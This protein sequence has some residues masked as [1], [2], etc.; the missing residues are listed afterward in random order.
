MQEWTTCK[1]GL[2]VK[3][4]CFSETIAYC[5]KITNCISY[6]SCGSCS[7]LLVSL[8]VFPQHNLLIVQTTGYTTSFY[9][10]FLLFFCLFNLEFQNLLLSAPSVLSCVL[11]CAILSILLFSTLLS[12]PCS[13][14]SL[15]LFTLFSDLPYCSLF[16]ICYPFF[17]LFQLLC[18][19]CFSLILYYYSICSLSISLHR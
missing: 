15:C 1:R 18:S 17:S 9:F 13:V 4:Y 19:V 5:L 11:F 8:E 14:F 2:Y 6:K 3:Y 12:I 7:S 16:Q 10:L